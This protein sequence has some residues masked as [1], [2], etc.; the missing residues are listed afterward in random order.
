M[1]EWEIWLVIPVLVFAFNHSPAISQFSLAMQRNHGDKAT[2]RASVVLAYTA[3]LLTVF[4]MFF[5]WSCA[6]ALGA[7]GLDAAAEQAELQAGAAADAG[8]AL[9]IHGL[10]AGEQA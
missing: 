10:L 1:V 4:T 6:F 3:V 9:A 8:V 7:N 2:R 5:V